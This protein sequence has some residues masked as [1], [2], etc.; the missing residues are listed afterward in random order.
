MSCLMEVDAHCARIG[1]NYELS[2]H[3]ATTISGKIA[4]ED[5]KNLKVQLRSPEQKQELLSVRYVSFYIFL[6]DKIILSV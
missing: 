4:F 3:T 2:A 1:T 6:L 5:G